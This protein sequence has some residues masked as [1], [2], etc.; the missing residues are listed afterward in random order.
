[1]RTVLLPIHPKYAEQILTGVKMFEY[2]KRG[3]NKCP[4]VFLLYATAPISK[5]VGQVNVDYSAT[6][7]PLFFWMATAK[8]IMTEEE[9]WGMFKGRDEIT[10]Y[11]LSIPVRY[12]EPRPLSHYGI[13]HAPQSYLTIKNPPPTQ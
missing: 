13:K 2:R 9:F 10:S 11:N 6:S 1:M 8:A 4:E 3:L 5:V 12:D 7:N